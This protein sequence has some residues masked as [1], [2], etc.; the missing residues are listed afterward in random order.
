MQKLWPDLYAI[1]P[2][3]AS[4]PATTAFLLV[5]RQGNVLFATKADISHATEAILDKGALA[6]IFIGDRHH[7]S[8]ATLALAERLLLP[9]SGSKPEDA[10]LRRKRLG[11]G[12]VYTYDTHEIGDDLRV[13]P[14]PGHTQGAFSYL[15]RSGKKKVLFV[16]DTLV[17]V[18]GQWRYWVTSKNIDT[19]INTMMALKDLDF[20]T[21]AVNSFACTDGPLFTFSQ[22]EKM[23]M[24]DDV[25]ERLR[26]T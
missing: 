22:A 19:M 25:I 11:I 6:H 9:I 14:T 5:R 1:K 13:H 10:V 17:H 20:N 18:D 7:V 12:K 16:G 4:E 21:V 24:I 26:S 23:T 2:A 3:D 8:A 15:W